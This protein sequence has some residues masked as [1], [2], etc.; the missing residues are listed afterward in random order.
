MFELKL[1]HIVYTAMFSISLFVSGAYLTTQEMER[2]RIERSTPKSKE[3]RIEAARAQPLYGVTTVRNG[4]EVT[5]E[6]K[7]PLVLGNN[8][9]QGI[10]GFPQNDKKAIYWLSRAVDSGNSEALIELYYVYMKNSNDDNS[11]KRAFSVLNRGAIN[12]VARAQFLLGTYYDPMLQDLSGQD[13]YKRFSNVAQRLNLT[14]DIEKAK[15][16]YELSANQGDVEAQVLLGVM[17]SSN[18]YI[19]QDRAVSKEWF[20]KSCDN[21]SRF[22]C[23]LYKRS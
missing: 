15:H 1:K 8:F 20:G 7:D 3:E 5:A 10:N 21:G 22:G 4:K 14:T 9:S 23:D 12:G 11:V 19:E 13:E 17:Y 6:S 18:K 16:L 2:A